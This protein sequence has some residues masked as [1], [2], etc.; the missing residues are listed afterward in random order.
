[1]MNTDT[2]IEIARSRSQL[3]TPGCGDPGSTSTLALRLHLHASALSTLF[4]HLCPIP[5]MPRLSRHSV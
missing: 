4:Y 5:G 1:M 3:R 2:M